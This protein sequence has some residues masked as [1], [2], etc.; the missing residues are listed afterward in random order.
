[1]LTWYRERALSR[2]GYNWSDCVSC[3]V[4]WKLVISLVVFT[5]CRA[6]ILDVCNPLDIISSGL[7]TEYGR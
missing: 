2:T 3:S 6:G 7:L 4:F 1:M 5:C